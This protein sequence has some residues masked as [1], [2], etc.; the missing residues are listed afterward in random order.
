[1]MEGKTGRMLSEVKALISPSE[2]EAEAELAFARFLVDHIS[3]NAPEGTETAL[4]GSMAKRTFLRD[5]RDVDIFVLFDASYP[6]SGLEAEIRLIMQRAFPT[7]GYQVSYAEHPYVRFHL[8]GRRIDLVPAY[9]ISAASE[10]ISAV[11]RSVLHT[12]FVLDSMRKGQQGEVLLLKQFLRSNGIYGAEIKTEGFSGYLCELLIIR[13]GSFMG[14]LRAASK[15][16]PRV[17]IDLDGAYRRDELAAAHGRFGPFVVIDPTDRN[18]N[19]AAAVSQGNFAL[20]ASLAR[21]FLR[22]PSKEAFFREPETFEQKLKKAGRGAGAGGAAFVVS[23]PRPAVVDDVL[24]G[25]LKKMCAQL[26]A[27]MRDF[28]PLGVIADDRRHLVRLGITV[29]KARLPGTQLLEGPPT[30]MPEHA[31]KF[32]KSHKKA[33]FVK[34]GNRLCAIAPR[35]TTRA[36]DALRQFFHSHSKTKSH[37]AYH[38]EMVV[39]EEIGARQNIINA[40]GKVIAMATK[41]KSKAKKKAPMKKSKAKKRK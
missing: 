37:L 29:R 34:R 14:L 1:M 18:R 7:L 30:G 22:K 2:D 26:E 15:W 17:F 39:I 35:Q 13:Y 16:K 32:R 31:S 23:M 6:R 36:A 11:D 21:S 19:V 5:R 25:Q 8:E 4:V 40:K 24:W 12:F 3:R 28:S 33:K 27:H 41:K 20:F 10:R 9:K 38:E